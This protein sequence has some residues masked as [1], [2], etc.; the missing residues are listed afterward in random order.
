MCNPSGC[1][2]RRAPN[3]GLGAWLIMEPEKDDASDTFEGSSVAATN[4]ATSLNGM[5]SLNNCEIGGV[6]P[7]SSLQ[8]SCF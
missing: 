3:D 8:P 1:I 7:P 6:S 5:H 2:P 4:G